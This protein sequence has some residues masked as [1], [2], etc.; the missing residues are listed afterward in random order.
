[1]KSVSLSLMLLCA[2][3]FANGQSAITLSKSNV[4]MH[5]GAFHF[6]STAISGI[7]LPATG[8][9]KSWD[10]SGL[11]GGAAFSHSYISNKN[12]AFSSNAVVDTGLVDMFT[13]YETYNSN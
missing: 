9:N 2:V 6:H 7:S 11:S 4:N 5:P 10:C 1:M 8:N 12:K 3:V 13:P